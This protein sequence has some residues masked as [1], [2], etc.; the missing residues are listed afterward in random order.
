METLFE[1]I[2]DAVLFI[3]ADRVLECNSRTLELWGCAAKEQLLGNPLW[4][5]SPTLQP[6]GRNSKEE[7]RKKCRALV[8]EQTIKF[9]WQFI[10][11]DDL[12]WDAEVQLHA[13]EFEDRHLIQAVVRDLTTRTELSLERREG[14][15]RLYSIIQSLPN[16]A[17]GKRLPMRK[18]RLLPHRR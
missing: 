6:D 1:S 3:E 4:Q 2:H 17:F 14:R 10:R 13:F 9:E 18:Y 16:P 15:Q 5:L 8:L 12:R 7:I 11:L